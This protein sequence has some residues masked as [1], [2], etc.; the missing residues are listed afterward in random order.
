MY[1]WL[2]SQVSDDPC[3]MDLISRTRS[4]A[5][6]L[7]SMQPTNPLDSGDSCDNHREPSAPINSRFGNGES[8]RERHRHQR[9]I[10]A[11]VTT[12]TSSP[13]GTNSFL[14]TATMSTT[15]A[16]TPR[17]SFNSSASTSARIGLVV[18][19][20]RCMQSPPRRILRPR[21]ASLVTSHVHLSESVTHVPNTN[22]LAPIHA[23]FGTRV[24]HGADRLPF[25]G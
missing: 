2:A 17:T 1:D 16:S 19:M 20:F 21:S 9:S 7:K 18:M 8:R 11:S 23:E 6:H 25:G 13:A 3:R 12:S 4:H 24:P 5:G 15:S 14:S 10:A 22:V